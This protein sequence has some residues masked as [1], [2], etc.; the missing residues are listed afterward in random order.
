MSENPYKKKDF[1]EV[2]KHQFGQLSD[3]FQKALETLKDPEHRKQMASSYLDMLHK[4]LA[5]AQEGVAKYQQKIAAE[6][7]GDTSENAE[8]A[9][10]VV[11]E[12]EAAPAQTQPPPSSEQAQSETPPK[13]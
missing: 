3:E 12:P 4:G 11:S 5:K 7:K 13:D 1:L 6:T 10:T 8:A 9:D 2:A